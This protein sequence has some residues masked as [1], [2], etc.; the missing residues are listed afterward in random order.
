MGERGMTEEYKNNLIAGTQFQDYVAEALARDGIR[1]SVYTSQAA[2]LN[3]ENMA[4]IEIKLDRKFRHTG[5]LYIEY[6]EKSKASNWTYV[7]S[8]ILR[9]DNSWLYLIGD[10]DGVYLLPIKNL[11][12]IFNGA[13]EG[14]EKFR[15]IRFTEQDTSRGM[16]LPISKLSSYW[17]D[18]NE[19]DWRPYKEDLLRRLGINESIDEEDSNG[20]K[21]H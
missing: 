21:D 9:E 20:K 11:R 12:R 8:G 17:V 19:Y 14:N 5:N 10:Y 13:K 6:E 2:Q 15:D 16:L 7:K 4:G 1:I 3:G 18:A